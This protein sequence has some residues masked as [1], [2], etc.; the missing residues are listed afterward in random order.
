[1]PKMSKLCENNQS[2]P[3]SYMTLVVGKEANQPQTIIIIISHKRLRAPSL[4]QKS[5][6]L[7]IMTIV[8]YTG[9]LC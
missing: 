1:M 6:I 8:M 3:V 9:V 5:R 4:I 7:G 2:K